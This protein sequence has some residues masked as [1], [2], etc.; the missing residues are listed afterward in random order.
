[1]SDVVV[2]FMSRDSA[3]FFSQNEATVVSTGYANGDYTGMVGHKRDGLGLEDANST[4]G[5][6]RPGSVLLFPS[7]AII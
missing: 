1:L 7:H 4:P 2:S 3:A 5:I 6:T